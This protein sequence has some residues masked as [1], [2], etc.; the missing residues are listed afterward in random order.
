M[1][2]AVVHRRNGLTSWTSLLTWYL[3][4]RF[5]S[6][7]PCIFIGVNGKPFF[8]EQRACQTLQR[9]CICHNPQ[10]QKRSSIKI[11]ILKDIQ[12]ETKSKSKYKYS[13]IFSSKVL[14]LSENTP[15][16]ASTVNPSVYRFG[17]TGGV[18][19]IR[20]IVQI[21]SNSFRQKK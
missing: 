9:I 15:I 4:R 14:N 6:I 21:L 2:L 7:C 16:F 10:F 18:L 20:K 12:L 17:R 1:F 3:C 19:E 13:T 5:M 11:T 8:L